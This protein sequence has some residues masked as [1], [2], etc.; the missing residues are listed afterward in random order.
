MALIKCSECGKKISDK[1]KIC[2]NC[3]Y[4][5]KREKAK[6][7]GKKLLSKYKQF[8]S[9]IFKILTIVCIVILVIL[10]IKLIFPRVQNQKE[11]KHRQEIISKHVG[12]NTTNIINKVWKTID[13]KDY[14]ETYEFK[15]DYTCEYYKSGYTFEFNGETLPSFSERKNYYYK[16]E[17]E[18][19]DYLVITVF[20]IDFNTENINTI[21]KL[22]YFSP[23]I[24]DNLYFNEIIYGDSKR[25]LPDDK[26]YYELINE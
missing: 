14:Y 10:S 20:E 1:A 3:S 23:K 11:L 8:S 4:P 24:L 22:S 7:K 6:Q 12:G 26:P 21:K 16:V 15:D 19:E 13:N 9:Q 2:P 17:K 25:F 5:I 18:K